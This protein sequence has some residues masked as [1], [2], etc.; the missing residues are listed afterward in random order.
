APFFDGLAQYAVISDPSPFAVPDG[1]D[2]EF[3]LKLIRTS[4]PG[5]AFA[6]ASRSGTGYGINIYLSGNGDQGSG[7]I[8]VFGTSLAA[9]G[10]SANVEYLI[11]VKRL[12][13]LWSLSVNGNIVSEKETNLIAIPS[14]NSSTIA[15]LDNGTFKMQ[16]V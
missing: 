8:G 10:F 6:F 12:G 2:F 1:I 3:S 13:S 14:I 16:G 9:V 5:G 11:S 4:W 15:A 7:S